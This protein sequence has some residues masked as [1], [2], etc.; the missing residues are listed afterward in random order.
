M[1][2][3]VSCITLMFLLLSNILLDLVFQEQPMLAIHPV[4]D[5]GRIAVNQDGCFLDVIVENLL[6]CVCYSSTF[7]CAHL[8]SQLEKDLSID[9]FI[10]ALT[11]RNYE[12]VKFS[13]AKVTAK[14]GR[15]SLTLFCS[16]RW[17]IFLEA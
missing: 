15:S 17:P 11:G 7:F 1:L 13:A 12:R 4:F 9:E 6:P 5:S 2:M 10:L 16:V 14:P 3:L 8:Y